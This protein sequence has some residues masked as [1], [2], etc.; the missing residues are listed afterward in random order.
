M[1]ADEGHGCEKGPRIIELSLNICLLFML[2]DRATGN[3]L[4]AFPLA[5]LDPALLSLGT[6]VL[7][8]IINKYFSQH[9]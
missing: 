9:G 5:L 2:K 7:F 4:W 6:K 8:S 3:T 1:L